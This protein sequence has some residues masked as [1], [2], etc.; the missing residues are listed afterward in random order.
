[1]HGKTTASGARSISKYF[2][3]FP[4]ASPEHTTTWS[5]IQSVQGGEATKKGRQHNHTIIA[6]FL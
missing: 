1:M 2:V 5:Y 4:M 6:L 3:L